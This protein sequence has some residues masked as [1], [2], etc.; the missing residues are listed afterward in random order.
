MTASEALAKATGI[1]KLANVRD[2]RYDAGQLLAFV[3]GIGRLALLADIGREIEKPVI[4]RFFTLVTRRAAREPLQYILGSQEF[5]GY[6]FKVTPAVLIPRCD[7]ETVCSQALLR[8]HGDERVLDLCTGSG[9]LAIAIKKRMPYASITA[10]DLSG[11]ALSLARENAE[12]LSTV[13]EFLE[14]DLFAPLTGRIFEIIV[15]NPPYIPEC[16]LGTLQEELK[17][18]PHMSLF[19]GADGM[20]FYRRISREAADYLVPGGHLVLEIGDGQADAVIA[21]MS[22]RFM[23]ITLYDDLSGLKRTA[24]G[25]RK[26]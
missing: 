25:I 26:G 1:L 18:E 19:S 7:T 23:E 16:S 5:M 6:T 13:I 10:S 14:G 11:D 2:A 4:T 17:Y 12:Q 9:A 20:D 21:L 22:E 24:A 15:C 8:M 3:L